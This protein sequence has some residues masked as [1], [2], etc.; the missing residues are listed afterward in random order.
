MRCPGAR[1]I[2]LALLF[3]GGTATVAPSASPSGTSSPAE[4][5]ASSATTRPTSALVTYDNP[6]LGY[7]ISLPALAKRP[8]RSH[9]GDDD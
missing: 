5:P 2:A 3:A 7:R 8:N 9:S 1:L 4:S 6:I